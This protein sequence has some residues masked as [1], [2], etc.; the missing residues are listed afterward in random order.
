M[1]RYSYRIT[2]VAL[3]I[4]IC[5]VI[6]NFHLVSLNKVGDI[7]HSEIEKTIVNIKKSFLKN[8]VRQFDP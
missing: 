1:S 2:M 4:I 7:Y 6:G 8:T 5:A 3:I